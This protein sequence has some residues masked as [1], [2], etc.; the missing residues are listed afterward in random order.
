MQQELEIHVISEILHFRRQPGEDTDAVISRFELIRDRALQG[1]NFD[2][3]WVGFAFLLLSILGIPKNQWPLL[4]APTQ[5][6]LPAD[7]A[8]YT[9]FC[10]YVRRQGHLYDRNVDQVKN[11]TF[12]TGP[13]ADTQAPTVAFPA[14]AP[15]N[16]HEQPETTPLHAFPEYAYPAEQADDVISSCNSGTSEPDISDLYQTPYNEAGEKLYLAYRHAKRRWRKFTGGFK[17]RRFGKGKGKSKGKGFGHDTFGFRP[18]GKSKGKGKRKGKVFYV[19]EWGEFVACL[20]YTS[21]AA[22]E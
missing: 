21:D 13:G 18:F 3:S 8:Q 4:L 10:R 16:L 20:L 14:F 7:Q 6:A 17:R 12:Y 15:W 2:M 9:A 19:D 22:D 5:G 1:A 11:M